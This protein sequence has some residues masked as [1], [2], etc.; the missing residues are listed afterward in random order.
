MGIELPMRFL[1]NEDESK[2]EPGEEQVLT[3]A[4]SN[5]QRDCNKIID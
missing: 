4:L 3:V 5:N 1:V 2:Q